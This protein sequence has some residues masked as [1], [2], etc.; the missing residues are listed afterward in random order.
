MKKEV[1]KTLREDVTITHDNGIVVNY[2]TE[3]GILTSYWF[4]NNGGSSLKYVSSDCLELLKS[5][6]WSDHYDIL[7]KYHVSLSIEELEGFSDYGSLFYIGGHSDGILRDWEDNV[8]SSIIRLDYIFSKCWLKIETSE[9]KCR[10]IL[11]SLNGDFIL[12]SEIVEIPYYNQD[13]D[14]DEHF[15]ISLD[16]K[17]SSDVLCGIMGNRS[18]ID[19]MVK[20]DIFNFIKV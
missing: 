11:D 4:L 12:N 3:N 19:D 18:Y 17:L 5:N 7:D 1:K 16:V 20:L 9:L 14:V 8:L 13:E 6:H 10:E 15:T 2:I